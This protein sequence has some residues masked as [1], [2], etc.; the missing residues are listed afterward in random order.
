M[1]Q[2]VYFRFY[3]LLCVFCFEG[4]STV[5]KRPHRIFQDFFPF[6]SPFP[7]I[8][9]TRVES[10]NCESY[11]VLIQLFIVVKQ[12]LIVMAFQH[13]VETRRNRLSNCVVLLHKFYISVSFGV[14]ECV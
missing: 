6:F 11:V 4:Y 9:H 1:N 13:L 7:T 2:S 14:G 3:G 5:Y 8:R 12:H 10:E